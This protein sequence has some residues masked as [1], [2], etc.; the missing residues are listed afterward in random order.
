MHIHELI[1]IPE[2]LDAWKMTPSASGDFKPE[3]RCPDVFKGGCPPR[4]RNFILNVGAASWRKIN[5]LN[6]AVFSGAPRLEEEEV[7]IVVHYAPGVDGMR[8]TAIL[9]LH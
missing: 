6:Y 9:C 2:K 7:A 3:T 5:L 8:P 4:A 1:R